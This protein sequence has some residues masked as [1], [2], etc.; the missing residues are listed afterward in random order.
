M[1][2]TNAKCCDER[3][4]VRWTTTDIKIET[5]KNERFFRC[6]LSNNYLIL[7]YTGHNVASNSKPYVAYPRN[8]N[9]NICRKF[10]QTS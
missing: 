4:D 5:I 2:R 10:F 9:A 7:A 8:Y 6:V 1:G 3:G